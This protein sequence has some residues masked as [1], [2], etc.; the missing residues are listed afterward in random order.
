MFLEDGTDC[1]VD[2]LS[3]GV[4]QFSHDASESKIVESDEDSHASAEVTDSEPGD[5]EVQS[6]PVF[7]Q[8]SISDKL[9][10]TIVIV[11]MLVEFQ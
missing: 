3:E 6:P 5:N 7:P 10:I 4:A 2:P 9:F 1:E 11:S 8:G